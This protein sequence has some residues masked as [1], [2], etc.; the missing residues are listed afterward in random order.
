MIQTPLQ[1]LGLSKESVEALLRP[2]TQIVKKAASSVSQKP[3]T[4][5]LGDR[6]E[7]E[8]RRLK[9]KGET[10]LQIARALHI[11]RAVVVSILEPQKKGRGGPRG[12]YFREKLT[13]SQVRHIR[14]RYDAG[15]SLH[16]IAEYYGVTKAAI[17]LIGSRQKRASV[18]D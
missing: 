6:L 15:D 13:P 8:V 17:S 12:D 9:A 1:R 10:E 11:T 16:D 5:I 2:H 7:K 14:Q 18:K 4:S 3:A